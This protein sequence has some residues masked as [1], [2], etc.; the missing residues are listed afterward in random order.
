MEI[1]SGNS[2]QKMLAAGE[3]ISVIDVRTEEEVAEGMIPG[4]VNINIFNPDFVQKVGQLDKNK[5]YVMVC[6]SG[7]RSSQACM[8]MMGLGFPKI[9]NLQGGMMS[10]A[11]EVE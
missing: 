1:L 8:H 3:D 7:A 2:L 4:A 11:G 10:W 6:R 9:Y 5:T